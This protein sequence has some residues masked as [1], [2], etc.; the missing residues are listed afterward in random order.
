MTHSFVRRP[1]HTGPPAGD[2]AHTAASRFVSI[3]SSGGLAPVARGLDS[4]RAHDQRCSPAWALATLSCVCQRPRPPVCVDA[5]FRQRKRR[6]TY[7][8]PRWVGGEEATARNQG[9]TR[10]TL[11]TQP[12]PQR[13]SMVIM[14]IRP[15]TQVPSALIIG[16]RRQAVMERCD[17]GL[18]H[19]IFPVIIFARAASC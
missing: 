3:V 2:R 1:A 5:A 6:A 19:T 16:K 7:N 11:P 10:P 15:F 4:L 17:M 14:R 18:S 13:T 8:L 12:L 9:K